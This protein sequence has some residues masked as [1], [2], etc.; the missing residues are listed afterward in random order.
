MNSGIVLLS[1]FIAIYI[2]GIVSMI[3]SF[4]E[5]DTSIPNYKTKSKKTKKQSINHY[6]SLDYEEAASVILSEDTK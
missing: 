5:K 1:C 2:L 4:F 3:M 6:S